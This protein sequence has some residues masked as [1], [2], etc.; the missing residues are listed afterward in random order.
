MDEILHHFETMVES[1]AFVGIYRGIESESRV[2]ALWCE[3]DFVHP[4]YFEKHSHGSVF[5]GT[6]LKK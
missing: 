1:I 4:Q 2:S 6:P 5:L 3:M